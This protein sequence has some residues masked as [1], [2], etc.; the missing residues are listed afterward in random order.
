M[1]LTDTVT[2][3]VRK[4]NHYL[5]LRQRTKLRI[6]SWKTILSFDYAFVL[7]FE[8]NKR[9]VQG[10]VVHYGLL[11]KEMS[12]SASVPFNPYKFDI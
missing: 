2:L 12:I 5:I 8:I 4:Q 3:I 7:Q 9:N 10:T 6:V 11:I 1:I